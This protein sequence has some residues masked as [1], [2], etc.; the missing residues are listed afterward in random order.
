M[1]L[2]AS[3]TLAA[4]A[5]EERVPLGG[6]IYELRAG[7]LAHDVDHLWSRSRNEEGVVVNSEIVFAHRGLPLLFGRL[8]PHL[9]SSI[10]TV[11]DTSQFYAGAL[12]EWEHDS[13]LFAGMG[14]GGAVHDGKTDTRKKDRKELGSRVLFRVSLDLGFSVWHHHR[15][16]LSFAHISN[17]YLASPNEGLDTLGVR[18]GF[19]F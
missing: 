10:N 5:D 13:G 11:R 15:L 2:V 17:A 7:V 4:G 12:L 1:G 8:R 6:W 14:L 18:Y 19:R 3:A 9:G 16:M